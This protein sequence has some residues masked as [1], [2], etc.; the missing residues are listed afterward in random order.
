VF[1][2][3]EIALAR[4]LNGQYEQRVILL[5]DRELESYRL[6]ERT[7]KEFGEIEFH[8]SRAEDLAM[9]TTAIYFRNDEHPKIDLPAE[10]PNAD[11]PGE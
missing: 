4:S 9:A 7:K 6:Y 2:Q 3:E 1:T 11:A 10:P 5:T 8:A